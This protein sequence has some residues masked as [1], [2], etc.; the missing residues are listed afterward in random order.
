MLNFEKPYKFLTL[1]TRDVLNIFAETINTFSI[2]LILETF[3]LH[4]VDRMC[5]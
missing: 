5:A 4:H 2:G 1:V 3:R